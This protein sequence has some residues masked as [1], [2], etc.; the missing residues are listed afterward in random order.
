[1]KVK[2]KYQFFITY[3]NG[4]KASAASKPVIDTSKTLHKLGYQD[5]SLTF[6]N[7][8]KNLKFYFTVLFSF[9][10][11][12]FRINK[13][14]IVATQFP[15]TTVNYLFI[16]F[17][18]FAH[19]RGIKFITIIHD[20]NVLR[21]QASKEVIQKELAIL[22]AYDGIVVH[23]PVMERWLIENGLR[24]TV[25]TVSLNF[26]DYLS[27]PEVLIEKSSAANLNEIAFAGHLAKSKFVY[28]LDNIKNWKFN[29]YGG[30]FE[31]DKNRNVN[32]VWKGE[33]SPDEVVHKLEGSFGLV[34][35]GSE[36]SDLQ[37]CRFGNYMRYNN[38]F[39]FSLYLA[40]GLPVIAP[41]DAAIAKT[42]EK[43]KLGLLINSLA[44]LDEIAI[45][46]HEYAAMKSNVK[47]I[48]KGII[49]G[50]FLRKAV[51]ELEELVEG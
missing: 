38:P 5:Y 43:Y 31:Y 17:I 18:K 34:W 3:R 44:D 33:F 1:M 26:F 8:T 6:D 23:N 39:K 25:K 42:I 29:I 47:A 50:N 10:R 48:Q 16:Y 4:V 28:T 46:A 45:D 9:T 51:T 24:K 20:I 2:S 13:N 40:A 19:L 15:I 41:A 12:F 22:S 14:S 37:Q 7:D 11:F 35:D 32:T 27:S 49:A 21:E 30:D 36:A